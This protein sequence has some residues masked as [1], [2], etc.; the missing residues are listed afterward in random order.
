MV[1]RID[2]ACVFRLV[3]TLC[4]RGSVVATNVEV[5][6]CRNPSFGL[7]TKAKGLQGAGLIVDPGVQLCERKT[8]SVNEDID[9][10]F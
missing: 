6:E 4:E 9:L 3:A 8:L 1:S 2:L 10:F 7:A 5:C